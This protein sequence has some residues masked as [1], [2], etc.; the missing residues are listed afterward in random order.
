MHPAGPQPE[1][2][3]KQ[4]DPPPPAAGA[5]GQNANP[6]AEQLRAELDRLKAQLSQHQQQSA[7]QIQEMLKSMEMFKQQSMASDIRS[8]ASSVV[9]I[10]QEN[11]LKSQLTE[12]LDRLYRDFQLFCAEAVT[13]PVFGGAAVLKVVQNLGNFHGNL[14]W[15]SRGSYPHTEDPRDL[16][17]AFCL[18]H[19]AAFLLGCHPAYSSTLCLTTA[20]TI[21]P[22]KQQ[23][24][25]SAASS[26]KQAKRS[27]LQD[28]R[29]MVLQ[30]MGYGGALP[31]QNPVG[32]FNGIPLARVLAHLMLVHS[33]LVEIERQAEAC[34]RW[35]KGSPEEA[36]GFGHAARFAAEVGDVVQKFTDVY[37]QLLH[38]RKSAEDPSE[39]A[40]IMSRLWYALGMEAQHLA[41]LVPRNGPFPRLQLMAEQDADGVMSDASA[42]Y[43]RNKGHKLTSDLAYGVGTGTRALPAP[44]TAMASTAF[45]RV[46]APTP[47]AQRQVFMGGPA[48]ATAARAASGREANMPRPDP[49]L[50]QLESLMQLQNPT[51]F[52]F[53]CCPAQLFPNAGHQCKGKEQC[54]K[55]HVC[56][57]CVRDGV[58]PAECMHPRYECPRAKSG[59]RTLLTAKRK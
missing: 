21:D 3:Q 38:L 7:F 48:E 17:S 57:V 56:F 23:S 32:A 53:E 39:L 22:T 50:S 1:G 33:A 25:S 31:P 6:E 42:F 18:V 58:Q 51:E 36:A 44:S 35:L 34:E 27:A 9:A 10:S 49:S 11:V 40:D 59:P 4:Q 41:Q 52:R 45:G 29:K 19:M 20:I 47:T 2:E 28:L 43:A 26:A 24:S 8:L 14:D 13:N 37:H 15:I 30:K 55:W 5:G 12:D 46:Q 54:P 16:A